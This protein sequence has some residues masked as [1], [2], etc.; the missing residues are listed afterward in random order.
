[1][2]PRALGLTAASVTLAV[3]GCSVTTN[4]GSPDESSRPSSEAFEPVTVSG[5]T[6][7][8]DLALTSVAE[9]G[10][11]LPSLRLPCLT[12]R[13]SVDVS[14]L[15]G[16]PTLVN[17]WATW[18]RQCRDEMPIL[19]AAHAK[20]DGVQFVGVDTRDG[21][22]QAA[23]FLEEVGVTYPQ[24]VDADGALL[25]HTRVPGLPVTLLLDEHGEEIARHIGPLT[26]SALADLLDRAT[27]PP[28]G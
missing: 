22:E 21:P 4:D 6:P 1:M 11:G 15:G 18:C 7:C 9:S 28:R 14:A 10:S 3:A 27:H 25:A 5:V 20:N 16:Q 17:L 26:G 12:E 8:R 23:A 2:G 13:H 24:L 19:Q